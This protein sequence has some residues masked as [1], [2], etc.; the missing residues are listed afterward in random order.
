MQLLKQGG[1][2]QLSAAQSQRSMSCWRRQMQFRLF[3]KEELTVC[4]NSSVSNKSCG[5]DSAL[6][7]SGVNLS[8]FLKNNSCVCC[9]EQWN[10]SIIFGCGMIFQDMA[11]K[12]GVIVI[13]HDPLTDEYC[14]SLCMASAICM[15]KKLPHE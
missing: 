2:I 8:L 12:C 5:Y 1:K 15:H 6:I 13:W 3:V 14:R 11:A 4:P 7:A 9:Q 10:K